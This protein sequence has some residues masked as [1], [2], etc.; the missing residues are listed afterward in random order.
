MSCECPVFLPLSI[1]TPISN[2]FQFSRGAKRV[3]A[4]PLYNLPPSATARSLLPVEHPDFEPSEGC[5][6]KLLFPK[7]GSKRNGAVRGRNG[8]HSSPTRGR[9][10]GRGNHVDDSDDDAGA[11][12]GTG[13]KPA[14][15]TF[16]EESIRRSPRLAARR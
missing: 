11:D 2:P 4:N 8:M 10:R 7:K 14:K 13:V 15:L 16:A 9:G 12:E 5:T 3:Y 1:P 6:P